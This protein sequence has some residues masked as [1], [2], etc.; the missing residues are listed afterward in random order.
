MVVNCWVKALAMSFGPKWVFPAKL[1]EMLRGRCDN[2]PHN[3][4]RERPVA[5]RFGGSVAGVYEFAPLILRVLSYVPLNFSVQL[6]DG[7]VK[8]GIYAALI[9]L[10]VEGSN[11]IWFR[12]NTVP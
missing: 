2:L 8:R 1:T 7:W 9:S 12:A 5:S 11:Y 4:H 3:L 6:M 10:L